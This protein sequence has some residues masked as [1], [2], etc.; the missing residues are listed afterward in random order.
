M[1]EYRKIGVW[2]TAFIGDAILT[3]PLLAALKRLHPHAEIHFWVRKGL[4]ALFSGQPEITAVHE[5]DKRGRDKSL[6]AAHRLG[7]KIA[8]QGFDLWISAHRSLR[9]AVVARATRIETRIGYCAPWFNRCAY[10]QTVDR[11]FEDLEEIERLHQLLLPLNEEAPVPQANLVLPQSARRFAQDF[12]EEHGLQGDM[13]LGVHPG[14]TWPTKCWLPDYFAEVVRHAANEAVTVL[15]FGGPGEEALV[16]EIVEKAGG[17]GRFVHNLAGRL[18]LLQLA[19]V[20]GRLSA[21]LTN[22]SGPM[23]LAWT[24]NVPLVALFGPTV[25][26]LGF[27]PRG[28]KSTVLETD[29]QCRPCGLHGPRKCPQKHHE[30]MKRI[31]PEQ[32]WSAL[33]AKLDQPLD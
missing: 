7:R 15:V 28:K 13:V 8:G 17:T 23:H 19:A 11:R 1:K 33:R 12:W 30:C 9:S 24:Q 3:L 5:F 16:S 26:K 10:T 6:L 21:C 14:S 4:G 22:D 20:M 32:V 29:L 27:Y 31:T 2:Q 18:D 25:R